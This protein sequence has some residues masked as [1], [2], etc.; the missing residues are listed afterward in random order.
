MIAGQIGYQSKISGLEE[1]LPVMVDILTE[2][3]KQSPHLGYQILNYIGSDKD[4]LNTINT[5]L[6]STNRGKVVATGRTMFPLMAP[7]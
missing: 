6:A 7:V 1:F 2:P 5:F 4:L 3:G